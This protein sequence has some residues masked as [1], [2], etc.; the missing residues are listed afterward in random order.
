MLNT[1]LNFVG[2][3]FPNLAKMGGTPINHPFQIPLKKVSFSYINHPY[4][5][6]KN[7]KFHRKF[8]MHDVGDPPKGLWPVPG[9]AGGR[10]T[11]RADGPPSPG[12]L[13]GKTRWTPWWNAAWGQRS[14]HG[15]GGLVAI[16]F[17]FAYIGNFIILIDELIFFRG[18]AKNHQP[19][20]LV[21]IV[22]NCHVKMVRMVGKY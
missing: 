3:S 2:G 5:A 9:D 20:W 15:S 7:T 22:Q 1:W 19:A 10:D 8:S 18:V 12:A 16:N 14:R 4:P 11:A 13:G 17:I 21:S 6:K